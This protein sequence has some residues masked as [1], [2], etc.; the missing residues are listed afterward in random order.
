[1]LF[2]RTDERLTVDQRMQEVELLLESRIEPRVISDIMFQNAN[3]T[4]DDK[5]ATVEKKIDQK[6]FKDAR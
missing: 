1:M 4:S 5:H 2:F 6:Y 3:K